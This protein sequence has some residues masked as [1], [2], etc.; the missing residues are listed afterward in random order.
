M[1]DCVI[2]YFG[3]F[4]PPDLSLISVLSLIFPPIFPLRLP[5]FQKCIW[6]GLRILSPV[7]GQGERA[8]NTRKRGGLRR[9]HVGGEKYYTGVRKKLF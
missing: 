3:H 4:W 5:L 9:G 1:R 7:R 2:V 8:H 6:V